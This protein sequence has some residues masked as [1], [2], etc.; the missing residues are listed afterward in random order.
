[1][2]LI[3][4]AD[5][6][7]MVRNVVRVSLG[8]QGHAVG[9]V[10]NGADALTAFRAKRFDLVILDCSTPGVSG[11]DALRQIRMAPNGGHTPVL[12]L[13]ARRSSMDEEIAIRAGASDY[14]RKPFSPTRLVVR[15]ELLL[16]T[17]FREMCQ[18]A[19]R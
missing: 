3:L 11:I 15:C 16:T 12:M 2:A 17:G 14:L 18:A 9:T 8:R 10:C 19:A 5:D 7:E 1:M 4:V 13:T 6:D